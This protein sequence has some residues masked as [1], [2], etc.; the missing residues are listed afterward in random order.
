MFSICKGRS[1]IPEVSLI[2]SSLLEILS[3]LQNLNLLRI[4]LKKMLV[5]C[6]FPGRKS[7]TLQVLIMQLEAS[8]EIGILCNG[9]TSC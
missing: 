5:Y 7:L 6:A 9:W 3:E 1:G 8:D 4:L 2:S